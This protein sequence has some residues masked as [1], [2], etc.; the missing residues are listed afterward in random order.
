MKK[1]LNIF[2]QKALIAIIAIFIFS[3]TLMA[4][5][6]ADYKRNADKYYAKGDWYTAAVYYEKYLEQKSKPTTS[7]Y[8]PYTVQ[9]SGSKKKTKEVAATGKSAA[10][11]NEVIYRIAESYRKLNDYGKATPYY[12]KAIAFDKTVYPLANYYYAVSLRATGNY[13]EAEKQF[14][15]FLKSYT[16]KDEYTE[17]AKMELANLKFI[18]AEMSKKDIDA[19]KITVIPSLAVAKG[20]NYAASYNSN[21]IFF[22]SSRADSSVLSAKNKNPFIN[23]VYTNTTGAV[24]KINLP[25]EADTEQGAASLTA[26]GNRIY[27]TRWTKKEG[28]NI[29]T[30]YLSEKK[31]G[32][33]GEPIKLGSN[34]NADGF[35]SKQPFVTPD[36]KYLLY[37]SNR[38]G[39]LGKFDLWY[40]PLNTDGEPGSFL[41]LGKTVNSKE[42]DEAPFYNAAS[43]SL[44][45]A[46]NG[47]IGMGGF[48]LYE[49]KG[50]LP[51]SFNQPVNLG[52]PVN[53]VKDDIY[54]VNKGSVKLLQDAIISTDRSSA[55][56]LELFTINKTYKKFVTG[57]INDCKTNLPLIDA[58]VNVTAKANGKTIVIQNTNAKGE[59]FFEVKEFIPS[60]IVASKTEYNNSNSS[61]NE[62]SIIGAENDTLFNTTFCLVPIEKVVPVD[63]TKPEPLQEQNAYFDFAKYS[64]RKETA[65]MLDTLASILQREK[66]LGV[67]ILGYTDKFGTT[68]YNLKLSQERADAC[69]NYLVNKG[70]N[71]AKLKA[72]GKGACCPVEPEIVDGKDN[73][74]GRQAN[75]RV[76]FKIK[77]MM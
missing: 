43:N 1:P 21:N 76:E 58:T 52:Y 11:D 40:A 69:L 74:A 47:R 51:N 71:P 17:H 32:N 33:W 26:D 9:P 65:V 60:A 16:T 57:T 61:F 73:P 42:D 13:A 56:C 50:S 38:E 27:F 36:G 12:A 29:S 37:S 14:N 49:S 18:Q 25:S 23:N 24:Q 64:L 22:T 41:N 28:K 46:S 54:F 66:S 30:I 48:D 8:D 62:P 45:F 75:R 20:S 34:V 77:L 39:G 5:Y 31:N 4:Q 44:I 67:E 55:C 63:T 19:Y 53:S 68:E 3:S 35:S 6:V 72:T 2:L 10:N 7:G 70:V 59:Y 15:V